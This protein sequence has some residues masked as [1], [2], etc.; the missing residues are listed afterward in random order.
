MPPQEIQVR[1]Y[2][3]RMEFCEN[4]HGYWLD[5]DEDTRVLELMKRGSGFAKKAAHRDKW[6]T[7]LKHMRSG[8]FLS[9]VRELF[10]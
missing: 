3:L 1:L 9:K 4:Q 5:D 2:D 7:T 10:R 6:A 8:S